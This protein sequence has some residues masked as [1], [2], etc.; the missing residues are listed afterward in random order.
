MKTLEQSFYDIADFPGLD[1]LSQNW[2]VIR[3]EFN[4]LDAPIMEIDRINKPHEEVFEEVYNHI[5]SGKKYGW[6]LGWGEDG[7]N[8][9]WTQYGLILNGEVVPFLGEEMKQTV[10]LFKNMDGIIAVA[11]LKL[12]PR[13]ILHT[14]RHD[15]IREKGAL[16]F[17]L[18][19]DVIPDRNYNYLN[20]QGEFRQY[21]LG[22][23]IVF[24]GA[25]DHFAL[26]ESNRERTTLYIEFE[27][28]TLMAS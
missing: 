7:G 9:N 12:N 28:N 13:T 3:E 21:V 20:V 19:I 8:Y 25:L 18:P 15:D 5:K 14:H 2:E 24:D 26:N 27:K 23:P 1:Q 22:E 4:Q 17:H 16:Q 6:V 11:L 10:E